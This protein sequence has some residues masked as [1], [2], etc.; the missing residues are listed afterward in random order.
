M[1]VFS[2][3]LYIPQLLEEKVGSVCSFTGRGKD[4][5]EGSEDARN[6]ANTQCENVCNLKA[7][8]MGKGLICE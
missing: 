4:S 8:A 1:K 2:T 5:E 6:K 3:K 7:Y